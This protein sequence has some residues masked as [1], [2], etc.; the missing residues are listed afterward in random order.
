MRIKT[1]QLFF[2]IRRLNNIFIIYLQI[3]SFGKILIVMK[4]IYTVLFISLAIYCRV[5]AQTPTVQ[6]CL[7]A[8][9]V[10]QQIYYQDSSFTGTGNYPDEISSAGCPAS[11]LLTGE[12]NDVWYIFTVQTTG[13][14]CFNIIPNSSSDDYDWAVFNLTTATCADIYS[15]T[16]L[17]VSCSFSANSGTTGANGLDSITCA[18]ASAGP[19]NANIP[20][21]AGETYVLNISNYSATQSGYTLDFSCTDST[22]ISGLHQAKN[23]AKNI[24]LFPNPVKETATISFMADADKNYSF[25]VFDITVKPVLEQDIGRIPAVGKSEFSFSVFTLKSGS[26][27]LVLYADNEIAGRTRMM[28]IK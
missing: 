12:M 14:L 7:G 26:Y 6:D 25:Q 28:V 11:C 17:M 19:N 1:S 9:P 15:D 21:S 8:I 22:I 3:V 5:T 18:A 16:S 2:F 13:N 20:V 4:N 24:S 27:F 10:S 23:Q